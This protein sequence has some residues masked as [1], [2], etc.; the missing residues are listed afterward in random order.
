MGLALRVSSGGTFGV[1]DELDDEFFIESS[2]V[3]V[4]MLLNPE[5]WS[6]GYALR[7]GVAL[8]GDPVSGFAIRRKVIP[9]F[10]EHVAELLLSI[11]SAVR[12][13]RALVGPPLANGFS[14]G[15]RLRIWSTAS[16]GKAPAFS[17]YLSI[18]YRALFMMDSCPIVD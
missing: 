5:F 14:T 1:A 12:L 3:G 11:G 15:E 4:G 10:L 9:L 13:I 17:L 7:E 16:S 2:D 6:E 8:M 18:R